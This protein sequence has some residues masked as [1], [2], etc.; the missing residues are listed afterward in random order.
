M[1]ENIKKQIKEEAKKY[2]KTKTIPEAG[3]ILNSRNGFVAGA[4][5]ILSKW[6]EV[7]RWRSVEE[8]LPK[9]SYDDLLLK[10]VDSFG[11]E[12]VDVGYMHEPGTDVSNFIS[13]NVIRVTHWKPIN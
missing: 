4:N 8:E 2:A 9:A 12:A 7:E 3:Y 1:N 5:F 13:G 10:G 11:D 6:Q